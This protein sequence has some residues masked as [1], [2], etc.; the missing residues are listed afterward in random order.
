MKKIPNEVYFDLVS[1][2]FAMHYHFESEKR[3]YTF[4]NNVVSKLC[5][6]GH[7]VGTIIDSNVLVK[8]LRNRKISENKYIDE[9]F[10]FGNDF[11]SVK[12]YQ[13]RF[14]KDKPFGTR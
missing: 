12:Y 5:D 7:F 10:T 13:K 8:R 1:C 2:Q 9:K 3:L 11:Y 6:G 14:E 4:L